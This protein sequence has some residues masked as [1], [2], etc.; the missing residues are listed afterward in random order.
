[1]SDHASK[2]EKKMELAAKITFPKDSQFVLA[3]PH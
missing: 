1:M 3:L 2:M